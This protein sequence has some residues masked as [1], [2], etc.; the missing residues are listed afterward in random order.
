MQIIENCLDSCM[1]FQSLVKLLKKFD[2][3][4][5]RNLRS[6]SLCT[7][8]H[9]LQEIKLLKKDKLVVQ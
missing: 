2:S 7:I 4:K 9:S 1:K 6:N 3:V 8:V 5:F